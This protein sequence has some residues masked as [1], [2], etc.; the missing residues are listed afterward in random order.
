MDNNE[1]PT[2]GGV[3]TPTP[4]LT[5]NPDQLANQVTEQPI[6]P[7]QTTQPV[8]PVQPTQPIAQP[9]QPAQPIQ[10]QPFAQPI[11][12]IPN[13]NN[14]NSKKKT[15]II[16]GCLLGAVAIITLVTVLLIVLPKNGEKTVSCTTDT[17]IMGV[18][19]NIETDV[20][21]KDGEI[22]GGKITANVNLKTM[23]DYYKDHE[24]E[25]VDRMTES[26]KDNCEDHCTFDYNYTKGDNVKYIM[27]YDKESVDQIVRS[28]GTE[29]MSAQEIADKVQK[30][31]EGY[32][33]TCTQ[34]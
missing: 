16:I 17:T 3:S 23:Q 11:P 14:K 33:T 18:D 12:N 2:T 22:S 15:G 10:G 29:N 34:H 24:Q 19:L 26:Y 27:Q 32:N 20:I 13:N 5:P 9:I 30:A 31:L 21:V 8:Q 7:T 25:M 6:P 4:T 1:I 28:Y